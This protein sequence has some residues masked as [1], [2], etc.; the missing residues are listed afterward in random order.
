MKEIN[1]FYSNYTITNLD[2]E[3]QIVRSSSN[4][5]LVKLI[6]LEQHNANLD[7]VIDTLE[8]H[9]TL[10]DQYLL[11]LKHYEIQTTSSLITIRSIYQYSL[12]TLRQEIEQRRQK[13]IYFQPE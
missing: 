6:R 9:L 5:Y 13:L 2:E 1:N 10:N 12:L 8:Q 3:T 11:T 7:N 4:I